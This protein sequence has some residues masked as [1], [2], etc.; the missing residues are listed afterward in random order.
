MFRAAD[1]AASTWSR[2]ACVVRWLDHPYV[3]SLVSDQPLAGSSRVPTVV[4]DQFS[5]VGVGVRGDVAVDE[6]VD[7]RG[8]PQP[9]RPKWCTR[10]ERLPLLAMLDR[11]SGL[12][13][14]AATRGSLDW[15]GQLLVGHQLG[16]Q[17]DTGWES[18]ASTS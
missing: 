11:F 7:R 5:H 18:T 15:G 8:H 2:N 12:L 1:K 16:L 9:G 10:D 6:V 14:A 13:R 4:R 3:A 17:D